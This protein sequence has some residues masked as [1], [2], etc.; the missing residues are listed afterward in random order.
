MPARAGV[1]QPPGE[2]RIYIISPPSYFLRINR[3]SRAKSHKRPPFYL[4]ACLCL[5]PLS[6]RRERGA[7]DFF[8]V[9]RG[10]SG[11]RVLRT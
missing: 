8:W 2:I 3:S 7:A 11:E 9:D 5:R 6:R 1:T 4:P 10:V